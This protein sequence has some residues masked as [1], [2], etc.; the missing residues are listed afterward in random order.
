MKLIRICCNHRCNYLFSLKQISLEALC[1]IY[2]SYLKLKTEKILPE[3]AEIIVM[4]NVIL[5]NEA[6]VS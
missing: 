5:I 2:L 3:E 6:V 4:L 1:Y